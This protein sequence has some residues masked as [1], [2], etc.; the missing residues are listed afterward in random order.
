MMRMRSMEFNELN[1]EF[2]FTYESAVRARRRPGA[3]IG[4]RR[5][6][7]R[8]LDATG[9]A[10][11]A[12]LD[13]RR[14]RAPASADQGP[15]RARAVPADRRRG[16]R[17]VVRRGPPARR[18]NRRAARHGADRSRGRRPL[19]PALHLGAAAQVRAG[20]RNPGAAGPVRRGGAWAH[21]PPRRGTWSALGTLLARPL[22][23]PRS[24]SRGPRL[25][26]SRSSVTG[27]SVKTAAAPTSRRPPRGRLR[28]GSAAC[29][30]CLARSFDHEIMRVWQQLGIV[31]ELEHDLLPIHEV[32]LVRRR[33]QADHDDARAVPRAVGLGPTTCSSSHTWKPR[34]TAPRRTA[35]VE[36][37]VEHAEQLVQ[38][39]DHVELTLR[40]VREQEPG[41][42]VPRTRCAPCAPVA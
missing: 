33:R 42:L 35:S 26:A 41:R 10:L 7:V 30:T 5:P 37:G 28:S 11:A 16:R 36:R 6:R 23:Q 9:L 38:H 22:R 14:G 25:R 8:A 19:R 4:G 2:G 31:D 21:P 29:T 1:V 27:Q 13:R 40:G 17:G 15:R 20:G 12:C 24:P 3:A 34:S 32:P 39:P 18:R